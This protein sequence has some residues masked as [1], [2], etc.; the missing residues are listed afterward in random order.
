[1]KSATEQYSESVVWLIP[2]GKVFSPCDQ[3][4]VR[5]VERVTSQPSFDEEEVVVSS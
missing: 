5:K 1:M 3:L 4:P 2:T